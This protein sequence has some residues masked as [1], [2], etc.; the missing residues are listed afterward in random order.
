M[1]MAELF[2]VNQI[3]VLSFLFSEQRSDEEVGKVRASQEIECFFLGAVPWSV[4]TRTYS[5]EDQDFL[6]SGDRE[7]QQRPA[8]D[9]EEKEREVQLHFSNI[10]R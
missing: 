7:G 1:L 8:E 5:L 4:E 9:Q 3:M 10:N 6:F 2:L